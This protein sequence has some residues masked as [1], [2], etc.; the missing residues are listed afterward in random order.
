MEIWICQN[1]KS[2]LPIFLMDIPQALRW[3]VFTVSSE[4]TLI[5][6]KNGHDTSDRLDE[7]IPF[8]LGQWYEQWFDE[9]RNK[10]T[11]SRPRSLLPPLPR[12]SADTRLRLLTRL[13][14]VL[15]GLVEALVQLEDA[16]LADG[17]GDG[18]GD[19][20]GRLLESFL[21]AHALSKNKKHENT[22][23]H[24][25]RHGIKFEEKKNETKRE[26]NK[27]S[28]SAFG[29]MTIYSRSRPQTDILRYI[30]LQ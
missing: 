15:S 28:S 24:R 12:V 20:L 8:N 30:Y 29:Q 11:T 22:C 16:A 10:A 13:K 25:S 3:Q 18:A 7:K 1:S 4:K 27:K 21:R 9:R 14:L 2:F 26:K 5:T 6:H 19:G 23:G 17:L